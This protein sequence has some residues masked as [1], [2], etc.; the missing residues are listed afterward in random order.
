M[1]KIQQQ[2]WEASFLLLRNRLERYRN[3]IALVEFAREIGYVDINELR[4][5]LISE[6]FVV[7]CRRDGEMILAHKGRRHKR[8]MHKPGQTSSLPPSDQ[9]RYPQDIRERHERVHKMH[10]SLR[11]DPS[12]FALSHRQALLL[13]QRGQAWRALRDALCLA[14]SADCRASFSV[15]LSLASRY[16][17]RE[18]GPDSRALTQLESLLQK[19]DHQGRAALIKAMTTLAQGKGNAVINHLLAVLGSKEPACAQIPYAQIP[20]MPR[21]TMCRSQDQSAFLLRAGVQ[22]VR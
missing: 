11:L 12:P 7:L 4:G 5:S 19:T 16:H 9:T 18:Q 1:K 17:S 13:E 3:P 20:P 2:S 8:C 10:D 22:A 15:N 14:L 6:G 21:S